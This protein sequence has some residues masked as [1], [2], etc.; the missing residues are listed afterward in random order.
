MVMMLG[1]DIPS[2]AKCNIAEM[3]KL[4]AGAMH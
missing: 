3:A 2:R 1:S 4:R